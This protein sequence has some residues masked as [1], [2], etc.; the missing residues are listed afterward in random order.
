[1][2]P[3]KTNED[4]V[5]LQELAISLLAAFYKPIIFIGFLTTNEQRRQLIQQPVPPS[6][7]QKAKIISK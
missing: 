6:L 4:S 3:R 7:W 5:R 1:M 2:P